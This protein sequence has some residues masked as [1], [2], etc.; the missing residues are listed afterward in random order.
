MRFACWMTKATNT[1]S[2]YVTY[3][4][5]AWQQWLRKHASILR[6]AYIACL[7][8]YTSKLFE[9]HKILQFCILDIVVL[10]SKRAV[11]ALKNGYFFC[12]L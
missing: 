1:D 8:S 10:I 11:T 12:S 4:A 5:S 9:C 7:F 2:E 3:I 6:Y